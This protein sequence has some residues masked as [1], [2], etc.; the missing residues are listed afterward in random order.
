MHVEGVA[1]NVSLIELR[2][3]I[4]ANQILSLF[5][6]FNAR[7]LKAPSPPSSRSTESVKSLL[8]NDFATIMLRYAH[9][10]A[11]KVGVENAELGVSYFRGTHSVS[12]L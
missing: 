9:A 1:D 2:T 10:C 5:Y 4:L 11:Q 6:I 8:S 7:K 12:G 3:F